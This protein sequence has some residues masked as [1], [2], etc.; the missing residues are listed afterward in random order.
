MGE[1]LKQHL[2]GVGIAGLLAL[3]AWLLRRGVGK[4]DGHEA[5]IAG[6]EKDRVTRDD[7][8][9]LRASLTATVAHAQERTETRLD[10]ILERLAK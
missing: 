7:L 10:R 2:V 8:D 1:W 6:L 5:R 9:E 3:I 4:V